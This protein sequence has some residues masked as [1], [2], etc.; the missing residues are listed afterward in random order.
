MEKSGFKKLIR[1]DVILHVQDALA[2]DFDMAAP[3][4]NTTSATV[5]TVVDQTFV[6]NMPLNGRDFTFLAQLSAV[7][8]P[9]GH[10]RIGRQRKLCRKRVASRPDW[11]SICTLIELEA[12]GKSPGDGISDTDARITVSALLRCYISAIGAA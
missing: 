8:G 11:Q 2:I 10:A 3:L 1:P 12:S 9:A 4:V 6:E 5:S 7:T